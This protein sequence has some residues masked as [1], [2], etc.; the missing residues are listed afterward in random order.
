MLPACHF[1]IMRASFFI[2]AHSMPCSS[3][4]YYNS[5]F[6][7]YYRSVEPCFFI[8]WLCAAAFS[9]AFEHC[10]FLADGRADYYWACGRREALPCVSLSALIHT[11]ILILGCLH[12]C[13]VYFAY[14]LT[15]I[16][17]C[18]L[19]KSARLA[20]DKRGRMM[21]DFVNASL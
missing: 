8:K 3:L 4:H 14:Q 2:R 9:Y 12:Q 21:N 5:A 1:A 11:G 13:G 6:T 16:L 15:M 17:S 10:G 7:F 20:V 19:Q 18:R